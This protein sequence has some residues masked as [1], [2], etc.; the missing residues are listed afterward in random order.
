MGDVTHVIKS[1]SILSE[2]SQVLY[3]RY[4]TSN[5]HISRI[6][7]SL[8]FNTISFLRHFQDLMI[9]KSLDILPTCISTN[10]SIL[11][12]QLIAFQFNFQG[13]ILFICTKIW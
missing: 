8:V 1:H 9:R 3:T 12:I 7:G 4:E 5:S 2:S 6:I 10:F 11:W 13:D